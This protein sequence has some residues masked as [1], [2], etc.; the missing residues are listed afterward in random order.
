[1]GI[2]ARGSIPDLWLHLVGAV[3]QPKVQRNMGGGGGGGGGGQY[4]GSGG[5][6]KGNK[7]NKGKGGKGGKKVSN[8]PPG[9]PW[10]GPLPSFPK[11]QT[12]KLH[13]PDSDPGF[14]YMGNSF[15]RARRM[16]TEKAWIGVRANGGVSTGRVAF[17]FLNE[18]GGNIR[19]GYSTVDATIELGMDAKSFGFGGTGTCS[20]AGEYSKYGQS[21]GKGDV[22]TALFDLEENKI[23]FMINSHTVP[24]D[25]F[26]IPRELRGATFFP[27]VLVKEA[28]FE[29]YFG[30]NETTPP[31]YL[32]PPTLPEGFQ[33]IGDVVESANPR[34]SSTPPR[35]VD[36]A[37]AAEATKLALERMMLSTAKNQA[38]HREQFE[39]WKQNVVNYVNFFQRPLALEREEE[40]RQVVARL[41]RPMV[42]LVKDGFAGSQMRVVM[43]EEVRIRAQDCRLCTITSRAGMMPNFA[44]L[45]YG[46]TILITPHTMSPSMDNPRITISGEVETMSAQNIVVATTYDRL[47]ESRDHTYR[48]DLGG[49]NVTFDRM[50]NILNRLQ[51]QEPAHLHAGNGFM[52]IVNPGTDIATQ[53]FA[54]TAETNKAAFVHD[55]SVLPKQNLNSAI[56]IAARKPHTE[57]PRRAPT[58]FVPPQIAPL[59]AS[60]R[61]AFDT[62][63]TEKRSLTFI[64]G[65]P[66]T[67]K[68]TVAV[69]V[70]VG[71]LQQ[72][73]GP[74]LVSSF[75]NQGTNNLCTGLHARGVD[76]VRVGQAPI[77]EPWS[78]S[79]KTQGGRKEMDVIK[80]CDV[81]ATTCV[82]A[83]MPMLKG[84]TFPFV[85][86]DEA[87]QIIEPAVLIPISKGCVQCL[88]IGDQCQLPATILSDAAR[89]EGLVVSLFERMI[90]QG[91][92]VHTLDTQ[93]RMHAL[94][95][96][97]ASWRFYKMKLKTGVSLEERKTNVTLKST[98][99]R[100]TIANHIKPLSFVNVEGSESKNKSSTFNTEEAVAIA[101]TMKKLHTEGN[102]AYHNIG[103]ITPYSAQVR[104]IKRQISYHA[105]DAST[106]MV[107]SVDSFQGQEN[108]VILISLVRSN[109][110]G[111][112][113][114]VKDWRRLNVSMTRAKRICM[115]FCCAQTMVRTP[116]FSDWIGFHA[117]L[118]PNALSWLDYRGASLFPLESNPSAAAVVKFATEVFRRRAIQDATLAEHKDYP[119]MIVEREVIQEEV[120][121]E[122][123]KRRRGTK[124]TTETIGGLTF[125]AD[126]GDSLLDGYF[127]GTMSD[128][129]TAY[130]SFTTEPSDDIVFAPAV[131]SA[132]LA[133]RVG[134]GSEAKGGP[135]EY[136]I[137]EEDGQGYTKEE[138]LAC[139]G[140]LEEW[141]RSAALDLAVA[142]SSSFSREGTD[143]TEE[144]VEEVAGGGG[145]VAGKAGEERKTGAAGAGA[146]AAAAVQEVKVWE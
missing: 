88:M 73:K 23:R 138:F 120:T 1:M 126:T 107:S 125:R 132:G 8:A 124:K 70:V 108:E 59:N 48:I 43:G 110:D 68:T 146:G 134:K 92:E 50:Q 29:V 119:G 15:L 35:I 56:S 66:G 145:G 27:H 104:E 36:A 101:T 10:D 64:Q 7:G 12:M 81:V 24:Q 133:Q 121:R 93:Y 57:V 63:I 20:H 89:N 141:T 83:G 85:V 97:F 62:V 117:S 67:G 39:D 34:S 16:D 51:R 53:L 44:E 37:E 115:L 30:P 91:M 123:D 55:P 129:H 111:G 142:G 41:Q 116:L 76:V 69:E 32:R 105:P 4:G 87:A 3:H 19:L 95:A 80:T 140:G 21:F 40:R 52:G 103:V 144:V 54:D 11:G 128:D 14:G 102:I 143:A 74:I 77:Y 98:Y 94:I 45:G 28:T 42:S 99:G 17:S 9:V 130:G 109:T 49:N 75:S 90:A 22:V 137:D 118:P 113:G 78:M 38:C 106:C 96:H 31:I 6:P 47:P 139:Y 131:A 127:S 13:H 33:W 71:W 86:I 58:G 84:L 61:K 112:I 114:F 79:A 60:Q 2:L 136:R 18:T 82:G 100:Q 46:R 26:G 25:A 122:V 65:P 72:G 5:K 135:E